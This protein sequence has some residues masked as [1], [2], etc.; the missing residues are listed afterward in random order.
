MTYRVIVGVVLAFAVIRGATAHGAAVLI[1]DHTFRLG[2]C[3]GA[4]GPGCTWQGGGGKSCADGGP[5][6]LRAKS[7]F[8]AALVASADTLAC[9][10]QTGVV[11]R[12]GL[13]GVPGP[14]PFDTFIDTCGLDTSCTGREPRD[15]GVC[16]DKSLSPLCTSE[17]P[18]GSGQYPSPP[19][20]KMFFCKDPC[21][22]SASDV[23][24]E[25]DL[26]SL[27]IWF[28]ETRQ[29]FP[30]FMRA[31]LQSNLPGA[32][33]VGRPVFYFAHELDFPVSHLCVR[34][35]F[36]TQEKPLGTCAGDGP[37]FCAG[38]H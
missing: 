25:A 32:P 20:D 5:C 13:A 12:F 14:T 16:K 38:D 23:F 11:L 35:F 10:A 17:F 15:C 6:E 27:G 4:D 30:A 7:P 8:A 1:P 24:S 9:G 31:Q 2:S 33:V 29:P 34:F 21:A 3:G 36:T 18:G 28:R 22:D 19:G 37:R 26:D